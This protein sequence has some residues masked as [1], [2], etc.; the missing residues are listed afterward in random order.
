MTLHVPAV[1]TDLAVARPVRWGGRPTQRALLVAGTCLASAAALVPD[2]GATG[3]V[4]DADLARILR[5]MAAIKLV[6]AAAAFVAAW[7]RLARPVQSWR[8]LAYIG[9]P[10]LAVGG[11]L[12]LLC[13]HHP[14]LAAIAM[15]IGFLVMLAAALTDNLF[16]AGWRG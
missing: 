12:T 1:Q 6:L 4:I 15:H 3:S 16:F 8:R 10:P 2:H 7:W 13:L 11:S 9:G 5:F 14:G